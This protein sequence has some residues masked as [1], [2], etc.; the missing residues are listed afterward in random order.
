MVLTQLWF[1]PCVNSFRGVSQVTFF[2]QT[3]EVELENVRPRPQGSSPV[4][5][6]A[7]NEYYIDPEVR[8]HKMRTQITFPEK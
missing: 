1:C 8:Q 2:L 3:I 4:Y 6:Y 5:E 7:V